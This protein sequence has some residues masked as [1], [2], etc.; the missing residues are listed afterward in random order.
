MSTRSLFWM[1]QECTCCCLK[2]G[3][4]VSEA[5]SLHST[6]INTNTGPCIR[7]FYQETFFQHGTLD[8]PD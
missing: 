5:L 7:L 4:I 2:I 6:D 8:Y 3:Y 1:L